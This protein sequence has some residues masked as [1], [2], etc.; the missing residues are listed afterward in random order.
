M[1]SKTYFQSLKILHL[2]FVIG[3]VLFGGVSFYL[4][5]T[6]EMGVDAELGQTLLLLAVAVGAGGIL[7]G[8]FLFTQ[9]LAKLRTKT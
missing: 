8:K 5:S 7:G 4:Q 2:A 3:L 9:M 1:K 6:G